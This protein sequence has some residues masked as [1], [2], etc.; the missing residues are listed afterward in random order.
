MPN[1]FVLFIKFMR[2]LPSHIVRCPFDV[3]CVAHCCT[4]CMRGYSHSC[5]AYS[6]FYLA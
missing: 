2:R 4:V 1:D 3:F 5:I 6:M